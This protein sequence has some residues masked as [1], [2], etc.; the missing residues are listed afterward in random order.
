MN[1]NIPI[2][3]KHTTLQ[4]TRAF[5]DLAEDIEA[6]PCMVVLS[7][8]PRSIFFISPIFYGLSLILH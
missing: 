3:A 1:I 2:L 8:K 5:L 7:V 4:K 6:I